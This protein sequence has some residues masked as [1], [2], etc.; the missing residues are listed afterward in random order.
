MLLAPVRTWNDT[1]AKKNNK[2]FGLSRKELDQIYEAGVEVVPMFGCGSPYDASE[3]ERVA[4]V[5]NLYSSV[6][7]QLTNTSGKSPKPVRIKSKPEQWM[8]WWAV[9]YIEENGLAIKDTNDLY[10]L[11]QS[12]I[13]KLSADSHKA[14]AKAI[15]EAEAS[16]AP[17]PVES[18]YFHRGLNLPHQASH[19]QQTKE[20]F[21]EAFE[22]ALKTSTCVMMSYA[23]AK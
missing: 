17:E 8:L 21:I 16:G 22:E 1:L 19:R 14:F 11:V 3:F 2:T 20:K 18:K 23:A 10:R 6:V 13:A 4:R 7:S 5:F 15:D 12:L 9:E